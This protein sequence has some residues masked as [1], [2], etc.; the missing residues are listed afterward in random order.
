MSCLRC[1]HLQPRIEI[2]VP[3]DLTKVIGVV[4]ASVNDGTLEEVNQ[5]PLILADPFVAIRDEGPWDDIVSHEFRCRGC[6]AHFHLSVD[7]YHGAG[8]EWTPS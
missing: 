6:G 8:G 4:R 3:E 2:D 5:N 1:Q 7:T